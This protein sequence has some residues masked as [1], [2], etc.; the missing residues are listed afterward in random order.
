VDKVAD[1]YD[2]AQERY[3]KAI[4]LF[5]DLMKRLEPLFAFIETLSKDGAV[6]TEDKGGGSG[7]P[8]EAQIG[9]PAALLGALW[10]IYA[11][12]QKRNKESDDRK[13]DYEKEAKELKGKVAVL[14]KLLPPGSGGNG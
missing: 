7:L 6:A 11:R 2:Q 9:I 8:V 4:A 12:L 13:T 14:E 10:Q 1:R 5:Q 3:D